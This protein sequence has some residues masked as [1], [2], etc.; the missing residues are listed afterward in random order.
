M[1]NLLRELKKQEEKL[2][3]C[4][5]C[6][7]CLPVCPTY[8]RLGDEADSPRGRLHFMRALVEG[9]IDASSET[10]NL[11]LDRCL[12]CRACESVCPSGVEYGHL[13]EGAREVTAG[14]G[15]SDRL[16]RI[17]PK[18][19]TSPALFAPLMLLTR[20]LRATGF[21]GLVAQRLPSEGLL[22]QAR[23]GM[24]MIAATA[25]PRSLE[26]Q[27]KGMGGLPRAEPI[28]GGR[29]G[30]RRVEGWGESPGRWA[31]TPERPCSRAVCK[32]A[33]WGG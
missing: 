31:T 25:K 26:I 32:R 11:H 16:S 33:C 29:R 5:H 9:R 12:G 21:P 23:L 6:G 27:G 7:F 19:M 10:L 17:L 2:F 18:V 15:G 3:N 28:P 1:T 20:V 13:L 4:V 30:R 22:G 24:G 8:S 14:G